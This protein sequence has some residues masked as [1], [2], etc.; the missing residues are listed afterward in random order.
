MLTAIKISS[1]N[2]LER[3]V[4]GHFFVFH[5]IQCSKTERIELVKDSVVSIK[6]FKDMSNLF[7]D[8]G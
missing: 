4:F 1:Y 5:N 8:S 3:K 2:L 6:K 7:V